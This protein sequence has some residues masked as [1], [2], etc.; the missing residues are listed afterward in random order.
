VILYV[1]DVRLRWLL[2][3][4]LAVPVVT[5]GVARVYAGAHWPSDAFG[6]YLIGG[7]W[8]ALTIQVYRWAIARFRTGRSH[9]PSVPHATQLGSEMPEPIHSA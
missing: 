2:V 6:G 8:L 1:K 7:I 9:A 5:I 4:L 3:A